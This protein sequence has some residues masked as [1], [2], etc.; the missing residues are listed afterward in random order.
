MRS[1]WNSERLLFRCI[2]VEDYRRIRRALA[3]DAR[4]GPEVGSG[5]VG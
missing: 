2:G 3:A 5:L 1:V 4:L